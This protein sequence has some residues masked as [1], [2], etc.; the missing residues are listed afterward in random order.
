MID[1][2]LFRIPSFNAS[3]VVNFLT[4][5]VA[6]GYFLFV[7]Q[8]LQLVLGLSPL[9]AGL[10]SVPS[11]IGFIVG[12]NLAPSLVRRIRPA[13]VM[14]ASLLLAAAGLVLL[15][16]VGV[17]NSLPVVIAAS[18][19]I[20][21]GLAPVL[22]LTTDLIV[23]SAPPERAGAASGISETAVELGGALGISVLG[24]LGVAIYRGDLAN[25]PAG[26]PADAAATARDTLGGAVKVASLLPDSLGTAVLDVSRG[27]FVQAMQ[28]AASISA[29]VAVAVALFAV[30]SLRHVSSNATDAAQQAKPLTET[31]CFGRTRGCVPATISEA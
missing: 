6:I 27:A 9:L 28:V 24:S 1:L 21:L 4:I 29:V 10:C 25:L 14:G 5:F 7:A 16:Q 8:Y 30:A 20:A 18:V 17:A 13:N 26:L 12:S 3:L 11:A 31:D 19:V 22:T 2:R 15:T 23:G